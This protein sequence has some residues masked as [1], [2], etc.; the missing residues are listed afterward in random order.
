MNYVR[1]RYNNPKVYISENGVA[2]AKKDSL[3]LDV[4]LNDALKLSIMF[5]TYT[6][7]QGD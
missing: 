2:G 7:Q 3:D 6:D 4:Q 5:V 1:D